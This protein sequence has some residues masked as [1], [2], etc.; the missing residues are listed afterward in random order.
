MRP[1]NRVLIVDDD[2]DTR[3][4][5]AEMLRGAGYSVDIFD[6]GSRAIEFLEA[7]PRPDAV[8][9]DLLLRRDMNGWQFLEI[10]KAHPKL[11]QIP[12]IAISG[13]DLNPEARRQCN[14]E[15]FLAKP[16]SKQA[17]LELLRRFGAVGQPS[18]PNGSSPASRN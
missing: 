4:G 8:V 16:I 10:V 15:A 18:G 9:L 7:G 2:T 3:E 17:L 1:K 14:A 6:G 13:A 12:V 11:S 5:I